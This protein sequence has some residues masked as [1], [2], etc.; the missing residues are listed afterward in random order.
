MFQT[1]GDNMTTETA[2]QYMISTLQGFQMGVDQAEEITDKYNE[3]AN[4]FAI[5]T[6]GIGEAL[7]RSAASFNAANTDLSQAIALVTATNEVVQ[8]PEAVGTLWKTLSARIRGATT[9]L[10]E[11]GEEEDKFTQ[12]TSKLR[13]LVKSLT[14]FDIMKNKD[15]YKSIYDIILGIGKEWDKL[16]DIEQASLGEALAGKRNSNALFAVLGN[17]DSLQGAYAKAESSA[18]SAARE[19]ENYTR[20][21]QYSID[22]TKASLEELAYDLLDSDMLKGGLEFI[23]ELIKGIDTLVEH[24]DPLSATFAALGIGTGVGFFK[25][26]DRFKSL[27]EFENLKN[28]YVGLDS[29][30]E[31]IKT[32]TNDIYFLDTAQKVAVVS[33]TALSAEE[34]KSALVAAGLSETQAAAAMATYGNSAA[35]GTQIPIVTALSNAYEGLA[36]SMGMSAGAFTAVL[37]VVAVTAVAVKAAYD[38]NKGAD[39]LRESSQDYADNFNNA[40]SEIEDYREEIKSLNETINDSSTSYEDS[41]AARERLYEIQSN[42][43]QNYGTEKES[44]EMITKAIEGEVDA[45]DELTQKQWQ[46]QKNAFNRQ[47]LEDRADWWV[48]LTNGNAED[49]VDLMLNQ[50]EGI[51]DKLGKRVG[52][53]ITLEGNFADKEYLERL[54]KLYGGTVSVEQ[55]EYGNISTSMLQLTGNAYDLVDVLR[56]LQVTANGAGD[57]LSDTFKDSLDLNAQSLEKIT[58][59]W[60]DFYNAYVLNE[61][62]LGT[63]YE[64]NYKKYLKD[65]EAYKKAITDPDRTEESVRT[66]T[67]VVRDRYNELKEELE[68][69]QNISPAIRESILNAFDGIAPEIQSKIGI[70]EIETI[71]DTKDINV[72]NTQINGTNGNNLRTVIDNIKKNFEYAEDITSYQKEQD[73]NEIR[74]RSY[75]QLEAVAKNYNITV[76]QLV[77]LLKQRNELESR[78]DLEYI[79]KMQGA[80]RILSQMGGMSSGDYNDFIEGL[81]KEDWLDAGNHIQDFISKLG[82]VD[83]TAS[84]ITPTFDEAKQ[85]VDE[86]LSG[87]DD[88]PSELEAVKSVL[89]DVK[90][91]SQETYSSLI[92]LSSKYGSALTI[93]NGRLTV[94]RNKLLAIA[95]MRAKERQQTLKQAT[96]YKKLE[97]LKRYKELKAYDIQLK[98]TTTDT[99]EQVIALQEEITQLDLLSNSLEQATDAF[100]RFKEAQE[101]ADSPY[102][103]TS[104]EAY[105]TIE[106]ALDSGFVG[107]DDVKMA[108]QLLYSAEY[109]KK[110]VDAA[111]D[112]YAAQS[113]IAEQW[114]KDHAKYNTEDDFQNVK[115]FYDELQKSGL[116]ENGQ[117]A[118]SSVIGEYF[119][120][121]ADWTNSMIEKLN[122]LDWDG[123]VIKQAPVDFIDDA[124]QAVTN[125]ADA[126]LSLSEAMQGDA[127]TNLLTGLEENLDKATS[128]YESFMERIPETFATAKEKIDSGMSLSEAFYGKDG[129]S[130]VKQHNLAAFLTTIGMRIDETKDKIKKLNDETNDSFINPDSDVGKELAKLT[131][132]Q[133]QL[134]EIQNTLQHGLYNERKDGMADRVSRAQSLQN[135]LASAQERLRKAKSGYDTSTNIEQTEQQVASLKVALDSLVDE[136]YKISLEL[137]KTAIDAQISAL[138]S[139]LGDLRQTK[140]SMSGSTAAQEAVQ[141]AINAKNA[142]VEDL[143]GQKADIERVLNFEVTGMDDVESAQGTIES[144]EDKNVTVTANAVDNGVGALKL[145]IDALKDKTITITAN[146]KQNGNLSDNG[147][148]SSRSPVDGTAHADGEWGLQSN[149]SKALVGE[150][151]PEGLVRDG[152]FY[153]IGKQGPERRN[154]KKGDVIFNHKQTEELLKNGYA[155]KR[156]TLIGGS[157]VDGT[158]IGAAHLN[159]QVNYGYDEW[160]FRK[161]GSTAKSVQKAAKET[162]DEIKDDIDEVEEGAEEATE[163]FIDWIERQI[164]HFTTYTE[165]YLNQ[166]QKA[167]DRVTN[168]FYSGQTKGI[169][170]AVKA[171]K[172]FDKTVDSLY[173]TAAQNQKSLMETQNAAYIAYTN[174]TNAVGLDPEYQNRIKYGMME[175][176][177]VTDET[178]KDQITKWQD[179]Y[180][181]SQESIDAFIEAADK[182]YHMPIDKAAQKIENLSAKIEYLGKVIDNKVNFRDRNAAI[183]EQITQQNLILDADK[184]AKKQTENKRKKAA[185]QAKKEIMK[186][187]NTEIK[188]TKAELKT[189][190]NL[191]KVSKKAKKE[192]KEA[193]KKT[194]AIDLSQLK[195]GTKAYKAAEKYNKALSN[196]QDK[197]QTISTKNVFNLAD[198]VEGTPAYDAVVKYNAAVNASTEAWNKFQ[199]TYEET[200]HKI[201]VEYPKAE[202][203]NIA[204]D[205][206][207]TVEMMNHDF[208]DYDNQIN[209]L[210]KA[211]RK[212]SA[213]YYKA[214][215]DINEEK[216]KEYTTVKKGER[217]MLEARLNSI[218]KYS[219]EW[220]DAYNAIKEIDNQIAQLTQ[221]TMELNKAITQLVIDAKEGIH[222]DLSWLSEEFDLFKSLL[223]YAD[224][225]SNKTGL[226]TDEGETILGIDAAKAN[227]VKEQYENAIEYEQKLDYMANNNLLEYQGI[228]ANSKEELQQ[229]QKDAHK[230]TMSLVK[231]RYESENELWEM[232]KEQLQ[233]ELKMYQDLTDERKESLNAEKDLYEYQKKIADKTKNIALLEK[234][235]AA[236]RGDTSQEGQAKRQKLQKELTSAQEDLRDTEY[237]R[238][239]S[240][241]Q[242]MLDDMME[243]YSDKVE[244]LSK[245][246]DHLIEL[247]Y[248]E[249]E[250]QGGQL[251]AKLDDL[252]KKNNYDPIKMNEILI[253]ADG[254][255][256]AFSK[257]LG[258]DGTV[259]A[260]IKEAN[261]PSKEY[262]D[263]IK[264]V[265]G[266]SGTENA[267]GNNPIAESK[268]SGS[269]TATQTPQQKVNNAAATT[270]AIVDQLSSLNAQTNLENAMMKASAPEDTSAIKKKAE[271]YIKEH[272]KTGHTGKF[273]EINKHISKFMG[274]E[275]KATEKQKVLSTD[276]L[277]ELAKIVGVSY[278]KGG[279][280]TKFIEALKK[281]HIAGFAHGGLVKAIKRNG[282]DGIATL[283]VGEAILTPT[284]SKN[285]ASLAQHFEA[286]DVTADIMNMLKESAKSGNIFGTPQSIDY[287]GVS[288]NFDLPNVTDPNSFIN[289]IKTDNRVQKAIQSVSIDRINNGGRLSVQRIK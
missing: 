253:G 184:K 274:T 85:S 125:L 148:P 234:Q 61:R 186:E 160:T 18:G 146:A 275:G 92:S 246:R 249:V 122:L 248:K 81:T 172:V 7:T 185:K 233:A 229:Y 49:N 67:E 145:K 75:E 175:I 155:T 206:T 132:E 222:D 227:I 263:A 211:G 143:E 215:K 151:G 189:K 245:N 157:F 101:T 209:L 177:N 239:I 156:G 173:K 238:Y 80:Y 46:Q 89:A 242:K 269:T 77:D 120:A 114:Q 257:Y 190:K 56:E 187:A 10:Q 47:N 180:D 237:D 150:L 106:D 214:Q 15:E 236:Y 16:T 53:T 11:L 95:N 94:N 144:I 78:A 135:Q 278:K 261:A 183:E 282:D 17:L 42:L 210:T 152:R 141:S 131:K 279:D 110:F 99:Y 73:Y 105:Q 202:F 58:S 247:A 170:N 164:K 134:Q 167:L 168:N 281:Y 54:A 147:F 76:S 51:E 163:N 22:R 109:Y 256:N 158:L 197:K 265:L 6:A 113:E 43:I 250:K 121:S 223:S 34:Q 244:T 216:L 5:D 28:K 259:V 174:L 24:L 59:E 112:G 271:K 39:E 182:F 176:E 273:G 188:E 194:R 115:N 136:N 267:K 62:I 116:M 140:V 289:V 45:L 230:T 226:F 154:L 251:V 240:D 218:Q 220:Y 93:Q 149:E 124:T 69:D 129:M 119:N 70:V 166:A 137:D 225:T 280:T 111:K 213:E 258:N 30:S 284:D 193:T 41:K 65:V 252:A 31:G 204:R 264:K 98:E 88:V 63:D 33:G 254:A 207:K 219:D 20:S 262:E 13:D 50:I 38:I 191:N 285:L 133:E 90:N 97:L 287:G 4:N 127:D 23:N 36:R 91:V 260:A 198:F 199:N 286:I 196:K 255:V 138:K 153:L 27:G 266:M 288:F 243:E 104:R 3:V 25:D 40:K 139:E 21:L 82:L 205:F 68:K 96:A 74:V 66:A 14:G 26:F 55:D 83:D 270:Q 52:K 100:D 9:E 123:E 128:Y 201:K 171:Y 161:R 272:A 283:K 35:M 165:R 162:T 64:D 235:L 103:E 268:S 84:K 179:F 107:T 241:Q 19:Q 57:S 37:A 276:E 228:I 72:A 130:D 117:L 217:D 1:V 212:V 102:Y 231:E 118:A 48:R 178:L 32:L 79:E 221:T 277:S 29:A 12:T 2:S 203:D 86:F 208:Q 192:I 159:D 108:Q 142:Q 195:E 224:R 60:Q 8:N 87:T 181:K 232:M 71:L 126:R 200:M 169:K 44:I